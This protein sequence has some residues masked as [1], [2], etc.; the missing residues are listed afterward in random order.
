[1]KNRTLVAVALGAAVSLASDYP[2]AAADPP[3]WAPAHGYRSQHGGKAKGKDKHT[4]RHEGAARYESTGR[5]LGIPEGTCHR[6]LL[7]GLL[8]GA[9]GGVLGSRVGKGDGQLAA[10]AA[11]AVAGYIIGAAIGRSMDQ[12]D[13]ACVGQALERAQDRRTVAWV[14]PD[15]GARYELTPTRTFQRRGR[16]CRDFVMDALVDG[17]RR[18]VT[19]TACR[20]DDGSWTRVD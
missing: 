15:R 14:D 18:E 6:E 5:A 9:V 16:Y 8:G 20:N 13:E 7:G 4:Y 2:P 3:P 12:V 10:T 11:G 19:G 1:M 17:A